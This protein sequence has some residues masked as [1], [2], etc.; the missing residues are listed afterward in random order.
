VVEGLELVAESV[1]GRRNRI[2][3][4]V[5]RRAPEAG[6]DEDADGRALAGPEPSRPNESESTPAEENQTADA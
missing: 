4:V 5:V 1:G 3:T 6:D 2:D